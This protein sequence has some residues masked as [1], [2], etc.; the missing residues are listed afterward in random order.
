MTVIGII[1]GSGLDNPDILE[2]AKDVELK[3]IWG[4]PSSPVK[5]GTIAG[6]EVHIIGRHGRD[7]TIPPT[8]V[9]NRANIQALKDLGCNYILATTAVGSLREKI[10]RGHLVIMDQFIDFTRKRELTFHETFEPHSPMHTPMAEPF[11][12]DL[13]AKMVESCN[14]LEITVHDKGTVVTIEGPRF[15]T[16]AESHMFRA[17]GADIIN[18][19][20]APEAIL[21]NEAGIPYAVVA[22]STDYDCWKTD[23]A[24]VT[25]DDILEIFQANAENVTSMLIKTIEKIS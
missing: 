24:P 8:Y 12:A 23:E 17:W 3:N 2:N 6:T 20:T 16:R 21:A 25:W 11:D 14:E 1:G 13:R 15:S 7:H 18:M 9:N 10:D 5:S 22:M 4:K 19:S